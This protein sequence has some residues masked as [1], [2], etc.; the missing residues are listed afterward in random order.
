[1]K[2][3][4]CVRDVFD[5]IRHFHEKTGRLYRELSD[6]TQNARAKM[7][8]S[9]M[10]DHEVSLDRTLTIYQTEGTASVLNTFFQYTTEET[11]EKFIANLDLKQDPTADDVVEICMK[12]DKYLACL[13]EQLAAVADAQGSIKVR[14]A[15]ENLVEMELEAK[16]KL[17]YVTNSIWRD[18]GA[19][20]T[21]DGWPELHPRATPLSRRR[22]P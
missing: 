8:L 17:A 18:V 15:L 14:E 22:G 19:D 10:A 3:F 5:N 13:F 4:E 2:T 21:I 9:Y 1:M 11:P 7:L 6:R 16:K 20:F 12:I